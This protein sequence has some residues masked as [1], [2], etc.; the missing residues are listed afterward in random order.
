M[1][2]ENVKAIDNVSRETS[3]RVERTCDLIIWSK[4]VNQ[5]MNLYEDFC[6]VYGETSRDCADKYLALC[7]IKRALVFSDTT[8]DLKRNLILECGERGITAGIVKYIR[9]WCAKHGLCL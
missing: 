2:E 8:F 3:E 5:Q 7:A 6:R 4:L 1:R 9:G